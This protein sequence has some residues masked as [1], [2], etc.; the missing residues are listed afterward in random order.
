MTDRYIARTDWIQMLGFESIDHYARDMDLAVG[1]IERLGVARGLRQAADICDK[2]AVRIAESGGSTIS[3]TESLA[4]R[5]E[6]L[7]LADAIESGRAA[8][9]EEE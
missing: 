6:I 1:E 9:A 8:P 5:D 4:R 3:V 7:A 2:A